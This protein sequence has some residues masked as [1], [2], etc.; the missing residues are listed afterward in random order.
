M[1][2]PYFIYIFTYISGK[3]CG[4]LPFI[5]HFVDVLLLYA[6]YLVLSTVLYNIYSYNI[7]HL[8]EYYLD[9][10]NF[11]CINKDGLPTQ[12]MLKHSFYRGGKW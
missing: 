8:Y 12:I 2:G 9:Y 4:F 11:E 10:L 6:C 1:I 7:H 5:V 3:S